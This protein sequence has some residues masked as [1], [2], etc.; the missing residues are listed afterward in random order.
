[1]GLNIAVYDAVTLVGHEILTIMAETDFPVSELYALTTT[2]QG[3]KEMSFGDRDVKAVDILKFDFDK[4]DIL[5]HTG[6]GQ[7]AK[8]IIEQA[9]KQNVKVVDLGGHYLFDDI[10]HDN[11]I[12]MPSAIA[13]QLAATLK[14][15]QSEADIKRVVVSTYEATSSEGKD[16]M[17]ELF[18]QSRKFFVHDAMENNVFGKQI[19]FNVIPQTDHFMKDGA[20]ES[21]WRLAAEIKKEVGKSIKLTAT[22][23][24]VPVF[25][26]HGMSVNVEFNS[27]I[28]AKAARKIWRA[29]EGLTII[30]TASEMEFVTPAEIAGEDAIFLSRIRDDST[31]DYGISYWITADNIRASVALQAVE[32]ARRFA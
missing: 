21:E 11:C 4:C 1:M 6:H 27:E 26:G 2:R 15:L 16:G 20:T 13:T 12:S 9:L 19:A 30:D 28:D 14:P 17:D 5:F 22:C 18:N 24:Q 7:T 29:T 25:I 3:G 32:A 31:V 10:R 8:D 23:V